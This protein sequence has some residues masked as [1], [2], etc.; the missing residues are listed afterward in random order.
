MTPDAVGL[1]A[2][3][4]ERV[5]QLCG[6]E[7]NDLEWGLFGALWSEHCSYKSSKRVLAWLPKEGPQV[8]AGPGGNAGVVRLDDRME[9]AFKVES[10]NHPS[11]VEPVQGAATG[12]GGI[13]RDIVA[14]GARPIALM[15]SLRFGLESNGQ[16]L[17]DGV[18][19]GIGGYGNAIGVPTVGGEVYYG[20][21]YAKNPLV[22]VLCVGVRQS[23][24][25]I[26]GAS[27]ARAGQMV[28]L[29]GQATGRD[30]I[31]GASLLASRDFSAAD[32]DMRPTVQV[33]DPY[34]GKLLMEATLA[35]IE[36]GGVAAVQDLGAAG[37]VSASSE[38]AVQSQVGLELHLDQVPCRESAMSGYEMMMSETQE[39][40]LLVLNSE[41]GGEALA[42]ISQWGLNA[43]PIGR[44]TASGRYVLYFG[45]HEV[46][47]LEAS[48]L[49]D[50]CP[51]TP[52]GKDLV[53]PAFKPMR[54]SPAY[55]DEGFEEGFDEGA[56][57]AIASDPDCRERRPIFQRYDSMIQTATVWG[58]DHEVSVLT[59]DGSPW[60][61]ALAVSGIGR[62]AAVDPY[63]GGAAAVSVVVSRLATQG[64]QALGLTDGLNAGNPDK[65]EVKQAFEQMVLGIR[66]AAR[67]LDVPVTGGNVSFHNETDGAAIWPTPVIG[68][69]GR[70]FHPTAPV[71]DS[72][73]RSD[74]TLLLI[75]PALSPSL[76]GSVWE[77]QH[78][79]LTAY[80]RV[81]LSDL[82][83]TVTWLR[84]AA[85]D[86]DSDIRAVRVVADG[87][88]WLALVKMWLASA[89]SVGMT[90][91]LEAVHAVQRLLSEE[92]G[93]FLAAVATSR[94][95]STLLKLQS[96]AIGCLVVGQG[97]DGD[98]LELQVGCPSQW[99]RRWSRSQMRAAWQSWEGDSGGSGTP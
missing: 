89:P 93:Q 57:M 42:A 13:I 95:E 87:G 86:V 58:P 35:A 49:V 77:R 24:D 6:R 97:H 91:T 88:L 75:N 65:P 8:V 16:R 11:Y 63:A 27:G 12:V 62:W 54:P 45:E 31:H 33:G 82:A 32:Q 20:P 59:V 40:M 21:G 15:D 71:A 23:K 7:P 96:N 79:V 10:H 69:V 56:L 60:G 61:L 76:G 50:G 26:I 37:L 44:V 98:H 80:P 64:A 22:N 2:K 14:M 51:L 99:T 67:A 5:R 47:N 94:V 90:V 28:Y 1:T 25:A 29:L 66:D 72:L 84:T 43:T 34:T 48:W 85:A 46:A 74:V 39:R 17:R 18:V 3:E 53:A 78:G 38:L 52:A 70:H 81:R 36:T 41:H 19:A 30:G 73:N 4:A 92:A 9:I 83:H 68:G 55:M